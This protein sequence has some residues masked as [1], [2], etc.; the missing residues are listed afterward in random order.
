MSFLLSS[1]CARRVGS[2]PSVVIYPYFGRV[3]PRFFA[4]SSPHA[5]GEGGMA[6]SKDGGR[7]WVENEGEEEGGGGVWAMLFW[8]TADSFLSSSFW[9]NVH[10]LPFS[11]RAFAPPSFS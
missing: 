3:W 1:C 4:T 10:L 9:E 6:G 8:L 2:V 11:V 5:D 7:C